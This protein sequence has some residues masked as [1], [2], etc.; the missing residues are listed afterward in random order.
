[1]FAKDNKIAHL[2]TVLNVKK[3]VER[4]DFLLSSLHV[5]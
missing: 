4:I 2:D 5:I 3:K 1:M